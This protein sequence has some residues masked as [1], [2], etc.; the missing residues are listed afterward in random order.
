M[1]S[2]QTAEEGGPIPAIYKTSFGADQSW[3]CFT[4][5]STHAPYRALTCDNLQQEVGAGQPGLWLLLC[6]IVRSWWP[7]WGHIGGQVPGHTSEQRR[8]LP[9]AGGLRLVWSNFS[10]S[11][12]EPEKSG[13]AASPLGARSRNWWI[14]QL[15]RDQF[16]YLEKL[17]E[18]QE[19]SDLI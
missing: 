6:V 16:S 8:R 11:Y 12:Y 9:S 7:G 14:L 15:F 13:P 10:V 18:S 2:G 1:F 19:D 17:T 5:V 4:C 3:L